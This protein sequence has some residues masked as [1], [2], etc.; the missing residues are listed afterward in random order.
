MEEPVL[1]RDPQT[2]LPSAQRCRASPPCKA[3][4]FEQKMLRLLCPN[5]DVRV[6]NKNG[7]ATLLTKLIRTRRAGNH[8]REEGRGSQDGICPCAHPQ[9]R[10]KLQESNLDKSVHGTVHDRSSPSLR[11]LLM[12]WRELASHS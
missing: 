12:D 1:H 7:D 4:D 9:N 3:A 5:G 10:Q 6:E 2:A 8:T 11:N